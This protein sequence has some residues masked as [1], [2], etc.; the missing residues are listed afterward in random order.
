[1][2]VPGVIL[3]LSALTIDALALPR[4]ASSNAL[5]VHPSLRSRQVIG[6]DSFDVL[7]REL[8]QHRRRITSSPLR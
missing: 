6:D 1:M 4:G 8:N 7:Q 5:S 2:K 3:A